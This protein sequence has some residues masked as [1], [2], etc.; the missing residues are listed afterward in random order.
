MI[1]QLQ[2]GS[3]ILELILKEILE[4]LNNYVC[5]YDFAG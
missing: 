4:F 1:N 5:V 3:F 2:P